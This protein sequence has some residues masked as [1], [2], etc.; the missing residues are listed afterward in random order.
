MAKAWGHSRSGIEGLRPH[1]ISAQA[2]QSLHPVFCIVCQA[3]SCFWLL[4]LPSGQ[5]L[6]WIELVGDT[7]S[8]FGNFKGPQLASLQANSLIV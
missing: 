5:E 6:L 3:S 7:E 1:L 2:G 8:S 4:P